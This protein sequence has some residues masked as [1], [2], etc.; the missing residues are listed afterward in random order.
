M[1]R[2]FSWKDVKGRV[3]SSV[4]IEPEAVAKIEVFGSGS[5]DWTSY[6]E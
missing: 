2:S 3:D 6:I 4:M 5:M 1:Q